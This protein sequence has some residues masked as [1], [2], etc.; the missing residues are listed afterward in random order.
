LDDPDWR[1]SRPRQIYIGPQ[2]TD[3]VPIDQRG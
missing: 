2:Q 1:I 3:Y